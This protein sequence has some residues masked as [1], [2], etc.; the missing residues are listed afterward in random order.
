[1]PSKSDVRNWTFGQAQD[2]TKR[3]GTFL[4]QLLGSSGA[5]NNPVATYDP[6]LANVATVDPTKWQMPWE[7]QGIQQGQVPILDQIK[8]A[9]IGDLPNFDLGSLPSWNALGGVSAAEFNPISAAQVQGGPT[10]AYQTVG[11]DPT[12]TASFDALQ[13]SLSGTAALPENVVSSWIGRSGATINRAADAEKRK[14]AE[15]L[16]KRGLYETQSGAVPSA[17]AA[18]ERGRSEALGTSQQEILQKNAEMGYNAMMSAM[19]LEL[20]RLTGNA[21]A[22]TAAS[23]YGAESTNKASQDFFSWLQSKA[24]Q[25]ASLQ[26]EANKYNSQGSSDVSQ[27]NAAQRNALMSQAY[28]AA[29]SGKLAEYQANLD[30]AFKN[31]EWTNQ[32]AN[33]NL[34][35]GNKQA[36]MDWDRVQTN[37]GLKFDTMGKNQQAGMTGDLFNA[38]ATNQTNQ[39]NA[40]SLNTAGM[41]GAAAQNQRSDRDYSGLLGGAS[42]VNPAQYSG[43]LSQWASQPGFW[44]NFLNSLGS[45]L[46]SGAATAAG[47]FFGF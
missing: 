17:M 46:G 23:K 32:E 22:S 39:F 20:Q 5:A 13:R 12:D 24:M 14:I 38:G 36:D 2:A 40:G 4:D 28:G 34:A 26:Q 31:T 37:I 47:G 9:Q 45:K 19:P 8:Y 21:A 29:T 1:M 35:Q 41:F 16:A 43:Q 33:V 44:G 15:D 25:N 11:Y 7:G 42:V 6:A 30:K 10:S 3:Q 27:F 18:A